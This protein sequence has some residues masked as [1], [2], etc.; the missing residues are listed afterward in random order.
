[1]RFLMMITAP[2]EQFNSGVK[3]GSSGKTMQDILGELKPE[4]AYL[5]EINGKRTFVLVV[6]MNETSE[7]P[8]YA[9]PF[10]L[11]FNADVQFHPAM[12]PEDLAKAGLDALGKKW[13]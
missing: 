1:M 12:L 8:K 11:K 5:T 4:A 13:G 10:F 9:E 7:M 2:H 6:N 3:D